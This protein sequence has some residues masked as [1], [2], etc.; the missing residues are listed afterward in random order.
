MAC[1]DKKYNFPPEYFDDD[2][3]ERIA[4]GIVKINMRDIARRPREKELETPKLE[5]NKDNKQEQSGTGDRASKLIIDTQKHFAKVSR[6]HHIETHNTSS[7]GRSNEEH[8]PMAFEGQEN[9]C[10][11]CRFKLIQGGKSKVEGCS[12]PDEK[13]YTVEWRCSTC[14]VPLCVSPSRNC[15]VEFH[16]M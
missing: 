5:K 4:G 15:F 2:S 11:L 1:R 10:W 13:T 6:A 16:R 12:Y 7:R 3:G 8:V 14:E 9:E